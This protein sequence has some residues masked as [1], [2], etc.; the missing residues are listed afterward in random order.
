MD[1]ESGVQTGIPPARGRER[2]E[3][4]GWINR[5]TRPLSREMRR[6]LGTSMAR[7]P[8]TGRAARRPIHSVQEPR[9]LGVAALVE[10]PLVREARHPR[11]FDARPHGEAVEPMVVVVRAMVGLLDD[12]HVKHIVSL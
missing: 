12:R 6:A 1:P 3:R 7:I 4:A 2:R 8:A 10:S 11:V 9:G 5:I